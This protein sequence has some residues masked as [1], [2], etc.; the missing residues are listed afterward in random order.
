MRKN[1]SIAIFFGL[2]SA[3]SALAQDASFHAVP[4]PAVDPNL[5]TNLPIQKVGPED[6]LAIQVY[7]SPEFTR[8]VRVSADG[9]IRL[10][11]LK[12]PVKVQGML[13]DEIVVAIADA[14][15]RDML[16]VDPFVTVNIAEYHSHPVSVTGAVKL[17]VIFQAVGDVTLLQ[18]IARA[19]GIDTPNAGPEVIVTRPNGPAGGQSVQR[20]PLKPLFEGADAELNLKLTG[21]EEIRVPPVGQI[22]VEGNVVKPGTYPVLDPISINTVTTAIAQAGGLAP[23]AEHV[24]YII[25]TDAQGQTHRIPVQLWDIQK[26][27]APDVTLQAKDILQVPDSPRRRITQT[28]INTLTGVGAAATSAAIY[29][30]R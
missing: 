17:P 20:I 23:Y 14:L 27:K 9:T 26:H 10:P 16:L 2:I 21:G 3:L 12:S 4:P 7:D 5:N 6:L 30:A 15:K 1:L 8:S 13:P 29:V 25:R 24:V 11:M 18:A 22:I 28:S 19:G